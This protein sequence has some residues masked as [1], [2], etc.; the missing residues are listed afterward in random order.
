MHLEGMP[1]PL[2]RNRSLDFLLAGLLAVLAGVMAFLAVGATLHV[3]DFG[4]FDLWFQSDLPRVVDNM[5][6]RHTWP[7][8]NENHPLFALWS[9]PP[10]L[11]FRIVVG[12]ELSRAVGATVAATAGLWAALMFALIR[13]L[14][15][16]TLDA[17]IFTVLAMSSAA[18]VFWFSVTE[19]YGLGSIT[20]ILALIVAAL[21]TRRRF[22]D[23]IYLG[24]NV[25]TL[26]VTVT[27]WMAGLS[28]TIVSRSL[29]RTAALAGAG[30]VSVV[31]LWWVQHLLFPQASFDP[32][33]YAEGRYVLR[34]ESRGPWRVAASFFLHTIAMP[35]FMVEP[36]PDSSDS[37]R[38]ML[39][40]QMA[41]PGSGSPWG[42]AVAAGWLVLLA[43]GIRALVTGQGPRGARLALGLAV[44]GQLLLHTLYGTETFLY[45][46]HFVVLL[47]PLAALGSRGRL[48]PLVL[49]LAFLV[50]IGAAANNWRQFRRA[51]HEVGMIGP[52][53][54]TAGHEAGRRHGLHSAECDPVIP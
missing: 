38:L 9:Y 29:R 50:T 22:P 4:S 1:S 24:L 11:F 30:L 18:A 54:L 7:S 34:E 12:G 21:A 43:L 5:T 19:T 46:L 13:L 6:A 25:L 44:V 23:W 53:C 17:V 2:L 35:A 8:H 16:R 49:C 27:N 15:A 26:S 47:V 45:A 28:A 3:L 36:D 14:G 48:R 41:I 52:P 40:T 32:H 20:I 42:P 33:A 31:A 10:T 37:G 39:A 51:L